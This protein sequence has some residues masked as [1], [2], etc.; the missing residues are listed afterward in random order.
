MK[1]LILLMQTLNKIIH[2]PV[3]CFQI[4]S[5][6]HEGKKNISTKYSFP[7]LLTKL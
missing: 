1:L 3:T 4:A 2:M 6:H 5:T 7:C